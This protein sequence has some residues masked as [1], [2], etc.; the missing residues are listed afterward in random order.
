MAPPPTAVSSAG[1]LERARRV[2]PGG[3]LATYVMPAEVACVIERGAGSCV[4]DLEGR[5]YIDYVLGSGPMI[6]GH[7]HPDVVAAV[8]RQ[9]LRGTQFYTLT[10]PAIALAELLVDAIPCA[11]RVKLVSSGAEAT[12]QAGQAWVGRSVIVDADGALMA[13]PPGDRAA[14]LVAH[15]D[16][17]TAR[18]KRWPG[19]DNDALADRRPEVYRQ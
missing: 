9:L 15:C 4:Y 6:V 12:F 7:C 3:A 1:L 18:N 13:D 5:E 11:D 10:E 19:T 16:L 14:L 2:L 17:A 8:E